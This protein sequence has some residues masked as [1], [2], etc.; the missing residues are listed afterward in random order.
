MR[1]DLLANGE[2]R[3]SSWSKPG[4][5]E[6]DPD[7]VL[8]GGKKVHYEVAL[9][10]LPPCDE[11]RFKNGYYQYIVNHSI[12]NKVDSVKV[13]HKHLEKKV[14]RNSIIIKEVPVEVEIEK[15]VIPK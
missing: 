8:T 13:E 9:N 5:T 11:Y 1:V 4:T 2:L 7:I 3:Y 14:Y 10:Q 6:E 12:R 15:I